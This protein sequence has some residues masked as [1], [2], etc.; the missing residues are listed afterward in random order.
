MKSSPRLPGPLAF[1]LPS[2]PDLGRPL[3]GFCSDF[4]DLIVFPVTSL[5]LRHELVAVRL[6]FYVRRLPF[7]GTGEID[8]TSVL[9]SV[10]RAERIGFL[11]Y[12]FI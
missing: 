5:W 9:L 1:G 8:R 11:I 7:I 4:A 6:S 10:F 3:D 12:F 2:H